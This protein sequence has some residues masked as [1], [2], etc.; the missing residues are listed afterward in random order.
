MRCAIALFGFSLIAS[1]AFAWEFDTALT[2][3]P[4]RE[5]VFHHLEAAGRAS[6]AVDG[7]RVGLVWE[8]NRR[9]RPEV[10]L[11]LKGAGDRFAAPMR[12]SAGGTAYEPAIAALNGGGFV[13]AWEEDE[14]IHARLVVEGAAGPVVQVDDAPGMQPTLSAGPDGGFVLAWVR[15]TG[16]ES[17]LTRS[18][19]A[20][21]GV[22]RLGKVR[23]VE[24]EPPAAEKLFPSVAATGIGTVAAWEDRR[25]GH[26]RLYYAFAPKGEG[27]G[28]IRQL[29]ELIPA[30]SAEFGRGT[31][32][33]RVDLSTGDD[34]QVAAVWMDKREFE[35]GYKV[36]AAL[37]R[38]GGRGFD[39]NEKV[40]DVFGDTVPQ[41]H[42]AIAVA[43]D[44]LVMAAWD[45]RRDDSSDVWMSWR[46]DDGWSDD[47]PAG[48]AY[49][50]GEQSHPV[51]AFDADGVLHMAWVA[52]TPEGLT[53]IRYATARR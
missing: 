1:P 2:V 12:I 3:A 41:W 53:E 31:G 4:A 37:S 51:L 49:G 22:L 5:G 10:Y 20:R 45:D 39:A 26:T 33:T 47:L 46:T 32:V 29:N 8:D 7:K 36:Y 42:P 14:R 21:E 27:F 15:K 38:D 44:G 11:A 23:A 19:I 52:R 40:Q 16:P 35:G 9:G 28:A 25:H 17:V 18:G 13:L 6:L 43:P 30:R 50:P 48:P 34:G 24:G